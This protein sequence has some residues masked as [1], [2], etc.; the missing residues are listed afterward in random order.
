MRIFHW[1]LAVC[2]IVTWLWGQINP[3]GFLT[4]H[5]YL[6]YTI[7]GLLAFRLIW[8]LFGPWPARFRDFVYAPGTVVAYLRTASLRRPSHWPGHNPV[9]AFSVFLLLGALAFQA[10]T[11]LY[12]DPDDFI[13]A[14][15][16]VAGA[17]GARVSWATFWHQTMAPV[18]LLLVVLH[19][20][21]IAFY[22]FWKR[23]NLVPSMIN[24]EKVVKGY[25]PADRIIED[26]EEE[27]A[28]TGDR[29][30]A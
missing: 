23:E 14:G 24:G 29:R 20:S 2:V 30:T 25:V 22:R 1:L 28:A 26:L 15:P 12:T 13:N 16:L 4:L 9:G 7:I 3:T 21:A 17:E 27:A 6:G 19:L 18:I 11:G 8:G 10:Y 5:F